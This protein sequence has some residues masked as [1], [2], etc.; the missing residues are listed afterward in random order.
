MAY[1]SW[2]RP[3]PGTIFRMIDDMSLQRGITYTILPDG[4]N[5][6]V[7]AMARINVR[8]HA[9]SHAQDEGQDM[10]QALKDILEGKKPVPGRARHNHLGQARGGRVRDQQQR[11]RGAPAHIDPLERAQGEG[12]RGIEA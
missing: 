7:P 8:A 3:M 1:R 12:L 9:D 11:V 6:R 2:D 5:L 4:R 10:V